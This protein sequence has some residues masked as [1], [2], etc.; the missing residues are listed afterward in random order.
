MASVFNTL[1]SAPLP[2]IQANG[3]TWHVA[4]GLLGHIT[5]I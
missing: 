3:S 5:D 1:L 2:S 4:F